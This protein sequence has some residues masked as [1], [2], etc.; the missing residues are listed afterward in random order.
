MVSLLFAIF[1]GMINLPIEIDTRVVTEKT[2]EDKM[3]LNKINPYS[4]A[5]QHDRDKMHILERI[6]TLF[7]PGSFQEYYPGNSMSKG[8]DLGY[9]GVIT[10]F[11]DV[12][13]QRVYF[14]GQDFTCMGG[15]FGYQH[16]QQIIAIIKE[17]IK[18][19]KPIIGL[20]D[21]GGARI[22]EGAASVVG[23]AELFRMNAMASGYVPQISI[24]AGTC[25]GGAVYSPGLTDFVFTID[26]ISNMFVTGAKVINKVQ[27]T[28]YLIEELGGAAIHSEVSGVAHFRMETERKC[29]AQVRRLIDMLP[30]CYRKERYYRTAPYH[31]KDLKDITTHFPQNREDPYDVLLVIDEILD[32][33]SF[34]EVQKEFAKNMVV[35]FGKLGGITVGIV[36]N[37]TLYH[38]GSI[39]VDASDKAAR[40][41]QY[42][43]CYNIPIITLTDSTGFVMEAEQEQKGLIRHGA[44]MIQAYA[45]AT[46]IRLTV[47]LRKAYGG[48]YIFMGCK[49]LG[50]DKHYVWPDVQV[51]VM[52]A[53]GAV[54]VISNNQIN[55]LEGFEREEFIKEQID[56]YR[57]IY[58]NSN[59]V[60]SRHF[61]DEEIKP[62]Q[63]RE[64]LYQDLIRLSDVSPEKTLKKKHS[65]IPM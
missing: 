19:K 17:A 41:V 53:E 22:Q 52:K 27:G 21:G 14:Y 59:L 20:Y 43:D 5:K 42:C 62:E 15:T 39:D 37:Q 49:Q 9:D 25:A 58:M 38:N 32:D 65:N 64:I 30:P 4:I 28:D 61:V 56:N 35:G 63:T 57:K 33:D 24:I 48:P 54:A 2:S 6:Q 11:G 60:L 12:C 18:Y 47:I 55:K 31:A 34:I 40:F 46:T 36:A 45:N 1:F 29:Y 3:Y 50:S 10:G 13:G 23:C 44:K 8:K 7:D 26:R 51:A 16:S